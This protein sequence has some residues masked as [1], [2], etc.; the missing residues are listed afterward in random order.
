MSNKSKLGI[1]NKLYLY[2]LDKIYLL[3][4]ILIPLSIVYVVINLIKKYF[5]QNT[6]KNKIPVIV[7]GNL[8]VGGTGKTSLVIWLANHL[9]DLNYKVGIISGGYKTH[10][11]EKLEV[12]NNGSSVLDVGD[13]ALLIYKK[14]KCKVIK[15]KNRKMACDH[16]NTHLVDIIIS[17]DGL[18]HYKLSRDLDIVILKEKSPFGNRLPLPSGPMRE[19]FFN[20]NNFDN[21]I[22]NKNINSSLKGF[23]Y[24]NSSLISCTNNATYSIKKF[25]NKTIHL[26]TA[27]ANPGLLINAL[28]KYNINVVSHLY[29]DHYSFNSQDFIFNDDLDIFMTEKD[30]VKVTSYDIAKSYYFPT[31]IVVDND[32]KI[33]LNDKISKLLEE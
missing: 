18:H 33:L 12:V 5:F 24:N 9:S 3:N 32:I 28:H 30:Y 1:L 13:E 8:T 20:L 11:P 23:Y 16:L 14:T 7:I 21:V 25:K 4:I 31:E 15:C 10:N 27:I 6:E 19:F 26:V 17:D 2:S 22:Y 29:P